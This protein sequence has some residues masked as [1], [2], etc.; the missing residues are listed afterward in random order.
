MK[1]EKTPLSNITFTYT[2]YSE[3]LLSSLKRI[4][5][6]F[7]IYVRLS[8]QGYICSDGNKRLSAIQDILQE[9]PNFSKFV[10]ISII[11]VDYARSA[12]PYSNHNN[13]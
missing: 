2:P 12:A 1:I 4:G 6:N 9:D 11:V 13:H 5:L 3:T 10:M 8:K 7:P